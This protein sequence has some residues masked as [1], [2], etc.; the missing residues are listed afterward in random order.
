[1]N[2]Q[3][4]KWEKSYSLTAVQLLTHQ[5]SSAPIFR[6][7]ATRLQLLVEFC[8]SPWGGTHENSKNRDRQGQAD[9]GRQGVCHSRDCRSWRNT[10]AGGQGQGHQGAPHTPGLRGLRYI[11]RL[12]SIIEFRFIFRKRSILE[13]R[14]I[15]DFGSFLD[16][17]PLLLSGQFWILNFYP[18][19]F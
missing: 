14:S 17:G 13:S 1:M 9:Q 12:K 6:T 7:E 16:L 8:R 10:L 18:F 3:L 15:I 4:Q 2:L 5:G 11:F 19:V